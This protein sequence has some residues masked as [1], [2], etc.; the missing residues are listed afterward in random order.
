MGDVVNLRRFK[1]RIERE[2][3]DKR[4]VENRVRHGRTK[5]ERDRDEAN[6]RQLR[7]KLDQHH[8]G[9]EDR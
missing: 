9:E 1:K 6:D 2:H 7:K 5:F 3:A 8:R 4:A